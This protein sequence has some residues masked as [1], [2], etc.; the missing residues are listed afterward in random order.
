MAS[1]FR[2]GTRP[3]P[4]RI[5]A[6]ARK[7][8]LVD[9]TTADPLVGAT[10]D[11][12]YSIEARL[13]GGGMAT[14]YLAH[15]LRL[16]RRVALKVMHTSLAQD[17]TFVRRFINE[18][19]AVAKLSHPNVVQVYDQGTDQG[20]VFLAMEYVPGRTLR[21][22]LTARGRFSPVEALQV[23]IPVLAALGAAHRAGMV[24]R[25][26]K[27]E[28]VLIDQEGRVK[29]VDFGLA[30]VIEA[31]QQELTRTGTLMG[32]AAYLSPEQIS[33]SLADARSDVY[34]AG[35]MLYE[36]LTGEQ[37]HTGE[38]AITVA[39][40][41]V[42]EDVPPPSHIVP[43]IPPEVDELVLRATERNPD[44]RPADAGRFLA[45]LFE[46]HQA[47]GGGTGP[48]GT[49]VGHAPGASSTG[50]PESGDSELNRT[51]VVDL[52]EIGLASEG[53]GHRRR[54]SGPG[55]NLPILLVGSLV[56]VALLGFGWWMLLG[57]YE[58]VPD[59][60]GMSREQA[61]QELAS[62]GL[63]L[64]VA[65]EAVYSDEA[66]IDA[67]AE[68]TPA[69]NGRLLPGET[70]TVALSKGPQSVEMPDV[71]GKPVEEART[72]LEDNGITLIEEETTVSYDQKSGT[73][74]SSDPESGEQA[75][76]EEAVT[77]TVS[78]GFEL[79]GVVGR[80]Q[81]EARS[82]LEDKGL[83]VDVTQ[84]PSDDVP[85][86]QVMEQSP[87]EGAGVEKGVTVTLTVSS[88]PE[89]V[90]IPDI[91][92]WKVDD[93]KKKLE[94]L[95]FTVTVHR[96]LGDRVTEYSPQGEAEKGSEVQIWATPFGGG[97]RGRGRGGDD[98]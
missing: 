90:E 44:Y 34:A 79:P 48:N 4:A 41:H 51:L 43:G 17:P 3:R 1:A 71:V 26:V 91:T 96:I 72:L 80:D 42:N 61:Q 46:V 74:L 81:D 67:I 58:S 60:V 76:R 55:A 63:K 89:Q 93:A 83:Q 52:D 10:L 9:M 39:Y 73:V 32:T 69:A 92:G 36:L 7:L 78:A 56:L 38:N 25:D 18:A 49:M 97:D 54:R 22:V 11:H 5:V 16:D 86:G 24:H 77:L 31:T 28:N 84:K 45:S 12:R 82:L 29:V 62:H 57:R 66:E 14:V 33:Q 40:Q 87:G 70:V 6:I 2:G 47:L 95:G 23:M 98:D 15:D 8:T 75:D 21:D 35:I 68:S 64:E 53:S 27:P 13:A 88:G 85:A 37:P 30:R 94:E 20:R 19:H 50:V 65:E 59:L